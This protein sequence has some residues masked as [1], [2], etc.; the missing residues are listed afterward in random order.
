MCRLPWL[1]GGSGGMMSRI[2]RGYRID[3]LAVDK[4]DRPILLGEVK[5]RPTT[6]ADA[7]AQLVFYLK[8]LHTPVPFALLADP[9]RTRIFRWD[10]QS[11]S[12]PISTLSTIDV[13]RPYAADL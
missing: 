3:L 12:G 8:L 10:G 2:D 9:E 11:L 13:L 7:E 1:Q 4:D 5:A 6:E